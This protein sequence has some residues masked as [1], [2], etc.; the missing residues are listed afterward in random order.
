MVLEDEFDGHMLL[1]T[2]P[3]LTFPEA[4]LSF[5]V[6]SQ[7]ISN[8]EDISFLRSPY[9]YLSQLIC[10]NRKRRIVL[11]VALSFYNA[12]VRRIWLVYRVSLLLLLLISNPASLHPLQISNISYKISFCISS[13]YIWLQKSNRTTHTWLLYN[14]HF[15]VT[16]FSCFCHACLWCETVELWVKNK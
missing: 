12:L 16:E 13:K 6:F 15:V 1:T 11:Q 8:M 5:G 14:C 4:L 7:A 2:I 10:A 9:L 3:T